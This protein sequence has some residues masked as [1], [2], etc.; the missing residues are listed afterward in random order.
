MKTVTM[1]RKHPELRQPTRKEEREENNNEGE[2]RGVREGG[3][4]VYEDHEQRIELN[5]TAIN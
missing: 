2:K 5:R 4:E 3:K 1:K